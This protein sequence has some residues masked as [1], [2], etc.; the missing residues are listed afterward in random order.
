MAK[1][2]AFLEIQHYSHHTYSESLYQE[3]S[4]KKYYVICLLVKYI[5]FEK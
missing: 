1:N 3:Q 2:R 4:L 5:L